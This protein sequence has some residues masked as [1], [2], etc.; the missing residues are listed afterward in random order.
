M[1][2]LDLLDGTN[3]MHVLGV[4]ALLL[5]WAAYRQRRRAHASPYEKVNRNESPDRAA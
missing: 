5:T 3:G 1:T 2:L 4:V